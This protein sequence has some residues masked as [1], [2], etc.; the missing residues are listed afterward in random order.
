VKKPQAEEQNGHVF[1]VC[2]R[3]NTILNPQAVTCHACG[4]TEIT[5]RSFLDVACRF[6][7]IIRA[8]PQSLH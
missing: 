8:K 1:A 2:K 3:C 4:S 5:K 6:R 7:D